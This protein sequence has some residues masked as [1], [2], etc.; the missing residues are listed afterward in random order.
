M[1]CVLAEPD[2]SGRV[3]RR[4]LDREKM[5]M[6]S[7]LTLIKDTKL[8]T[9]ITEDTLNNG[10]KLP[11]GAPIYVL[12]TKGRRK[13]TPG[14]RNERAV[15]PTD[16]INIALQD[17]IRT[18][19][20][21]LYSGVVVRKVTKASQG[22]HFTILITGHNC[23]YCQNIGREHGSNNIYFVASK[24]CGLV[25]RCFDSGDKTPEMQ[26]GPCKEYSSASMV[27]GPAAAALLWPETV[28]AAFDDPEAATGEKPTESFLLKAL[29]NNIDF[30]CRELYPDSPSWP[31]V[32]KFR[33][34]GRGLASEFSAQDPR[35]LGTRGAIAYKTLGMQ[36]SQ[37]LLDLI[38]SK[39]PSVAD[40]PKEILKSMSYYEKAVLEAFTTIV[41]LATTADD[42]S[43][44][45]RCF[46]MDEFLNADAYRT[47]PLNSIYV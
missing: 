8:R 9:A 5:Y 37:C 31:S 45:D 14:H 20:G 22:R 23:R 25:Q 13:S 28:V 15:D 42:P 36:W 32:A 10:F 6:E 26:Y 40:Q 29:I 12:P 34:T 2:A 3:N 19:F 35:D 16:P 47:E 38:A 39:N 21:Q 4:D 18:A 11:S 33:R 7:M 1:L 17:S 24:E 27:I 43:I 46:L 44:F 41:T 30:H